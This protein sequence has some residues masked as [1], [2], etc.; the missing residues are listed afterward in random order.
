MVAPTAHQ[1]G[2]VRSA[3]RPSAAKIIQNIFRCMIDLS[4]KRRDARSSS[5]FGVREHGGQQPLLQHADEVR[6]GLTERHAH[7]LFGMRVRNSG[8]S[9]EESAVGEDLQK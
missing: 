6:F 3:T 9:L 4:P 5:R 7:S 1:N 2:S 8:A